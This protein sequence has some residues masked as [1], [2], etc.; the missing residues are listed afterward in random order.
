MSSQNSMFP[1]KPTSLIEGFSN[2]KHL[3]EPQDTEF[4]N[5][6]QRNFSNEFKKLKEDQ[7]KCRVNG[8]PH[9]LCHKAQPF[10]SHTVA[11]AGVGQWGSFGP[12]ILGIGKPQNHS[13]RHRTARTRSE[14]P[15]PARR[16]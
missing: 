15:G 8:T 9:Q 14:V 10:L 4:K 2:E 3:D 5:N 12:P 1:L 13:L 16:P 11:G 6:N 7:G